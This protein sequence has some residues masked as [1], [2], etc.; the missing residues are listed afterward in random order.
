MR[1][2]ST[3]TS[4]RYSR[5]WRSE[6]TG[7]V[8]DPLPPSPG[9]AL[10]I[11]GSPVPALQAVVGTLR[12]VRERMGAGRGRDPARGVLRHAARA[13]AALHAR[14]ALLPHA[15]ARGRR[16]RAR[17]RA[18]RRAHPAE[19]AVRG[20]GGERRVGRRVGAGRRAR[21]RAARPRRAPRA[22][23]HT[24]AAPGQ[25]RRRLGGRVHGA[26]TSPAPSLIW[27]DG[28][29]ATPPQYTEFHTYAA[30]LIGAPP[31]YLEQSAIAQHRQTWRLHEH[32]LHGPRE[33]AGAGLAAGAALDAYLPE[34]QI[35]QTPGGLEVRTPGADALVYRRWEEGVG[36]PA[37]EDGEEMVVKDIIITGEVSGAPGSIGE[38]VID[39][40]SSRATRHGASS[41]CRAAFDRA[42][43]S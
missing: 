7:C 11:P 34:C 35:V 6:D 33:G 2:R 26:R 30:L 27:A 10:T 15:P 42:T 38:C 31:S 17:A 19:R 23:V 40:F 39:R 3:M 29:R 37:G 13:P 12:P 22:R 25:P 36:Q 1:T 5:S 9:S 43:A 4:C 8:I 20:A 16:V 21:P 41:G 24:R 18:R 28:A 32:H 14:R